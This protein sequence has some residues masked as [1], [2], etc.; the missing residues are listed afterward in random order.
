MVEN[1]SYLQITQVHVTYFTLSVLLRRKEPAAADDEL[2]M[3][4]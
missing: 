3:M 2:E 4:K 1:Q